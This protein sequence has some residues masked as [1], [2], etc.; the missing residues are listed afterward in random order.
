MFTAPQTLVPVL[1]EF[2]SQAAP[3]TAGSY[4]RHR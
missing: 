2:L 1:V 4:Q 3:V